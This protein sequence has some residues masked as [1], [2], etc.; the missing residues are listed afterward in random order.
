MELLIGDVGMPHADGYLLVRSI[1]R[2]PAPWCS[3]PAIALTA[4]AR[5]EDAEK[6]RNAGFHAHLAKPVEP[7][8]LTAAIVGLVHQPPT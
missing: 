7:L 6:A 4:F 1:R 5:A 3:I 8:Q 2:S